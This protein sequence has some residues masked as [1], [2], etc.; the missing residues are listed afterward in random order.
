MSSLYFCFGPAQ[1]RT[2]LPFA[3]SL[4]D[5]QPLDDLAKSCL[6][7]IPQYFVCSPHIVIILTDLVPYTR[8]R[9]IWPLIS[10]LADVQLISR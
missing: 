9:I 2:I 7:P 6:G 1:D 3:S 4:A 8:D 10:R 5:V